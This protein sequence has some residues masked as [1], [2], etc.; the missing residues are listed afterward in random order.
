MSKMLDANIQKKQWLKFGVFAAVILVV[1]IFAGLLMNGQ[2]SDLSE[3]LGIEE[4]SDEVIESIEQTDGVVDIE[5]WTTSNGVRVYYVSAPQLPMVDVDVTFDAGS[6]RDSDK[7]GVAFLANAL[8]TEGTAELDA[9]ALAEK[10]E[11]FGAQISNQS[12]RDMA[13]IHIRTLSDIAILPEVV[14]TV[15]EIITR[16]AYP[17]E[18]FKREQQNALKLLDYETQNPSKVAQRAFFETIYEGQPYGN[19]P[20]GT[21]ESISQITPEDLKAFHA[22]YYVASNAVVTVVGD[23]TRD[24][25]NA[26]AVALT[27]EL[28]KGQ[29]P[30][31]LAEV[32]PLEASITKNIEFPSEQTHIIVGAPSVTRDDPDYFALYVGNHILGGGGMVTRLFDEV[33]EKKGLAYSVH[34]SFR[35]MQAQ[36]PFIMGLQTKQ[37]S[38]KEALAILNETVKEFIE[39]GPDEQELEDAKLNILGGFPLKFDSNRSIADHVMVIGYYDLPVN[40]FDTYKEEVEKVT[41]A[42]IKDAFQRRINLDAMATIMVGSS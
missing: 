4:M 36:G 9:D 26:I 20:H 16:P 8:L 24:G 38:A 31:K 11:S 14:N 13:S 10:L 28:A 22:Q 35:P 30:Q 15:A 25:A 17:E 23:V 32:K 33:R 37:E 5:H 42:Q 7:L 40:Y 3:A 6:A 19:W 39:N 1:A 41:L 34:S 18:G 2:K 29:A 21:K 12:Q 27:D